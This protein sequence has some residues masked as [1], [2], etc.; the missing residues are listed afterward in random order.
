MGKKVTQVQSVGHCILMRLPEP[1]T[2]PLFFCLCGNQHSQHTASECH[3]SK[4]YIVSK[5]VATHVLT[6]VNWEAY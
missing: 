5:S 4:Q 2:S 6:Y 3:L 1:D